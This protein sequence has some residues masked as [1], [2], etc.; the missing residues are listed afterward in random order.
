MATH[1]SLLAWR[2]PTTEEPGR[3]QSRGFQESDMTERLS[4]IV[5]KGETVSLH[6]IKN[7]YLSSFGCATSSLLGRLLSSSEH[8]P[9][10]LDVV[11]SQ[12]GQLLL[13]QSTGSRPRR[14]RQ[15]RHVGSAVAAPRLSTQAQQLRHVSLVALQHVGSCWVRDGSPVSSTGRRILYH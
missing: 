5:L 4:T 12:C 7:F 13:L 6:F 15:L 1:S 9:L 14:L 11:A 8:Q 3:L 2:I 10:R